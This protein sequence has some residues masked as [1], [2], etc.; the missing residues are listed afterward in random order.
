LA[1]TFLQSDNKPTSG[2]FSVLAR[3]RHHAVGEDQ[4]GGY[5]EPQRRF[6]AD[7]ITLR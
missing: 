5:A 4:R 6:R 3:R 1:A 2:A 7:L